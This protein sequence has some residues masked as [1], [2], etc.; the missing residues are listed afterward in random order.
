MKS[1]K[2]LSIIFTA[3]IMN[4]TVNAMRQFQVVDYGLE[5][6]LPRFVIEN[7][8]RSD[9]YSSS[10]DSD[11]SVLNDNTSQ[12]NEI[13]ENIKSHN[14]NQNIK[15]V[16]VDKPYYMYQLKSGTTGAQLKSGTT[17]AQLK[18]GTTSAQLKSDHKVIQLTSDR[19]VIQTIDKNINKV[20]TRNKTIE[21]TIHKYIGTN[22]KENTNNTITCDTPSSSSNN[23]EKYNSLLNRV[24]D[25]LFEFNTILEQELIPINKRKIKSLNYRN[26]L[27]NIKNRRNKDN[28]GKKEIDELYDFV[29][30]LNSEI[31]KAL[32]KQNNMYKKFVKNKYMLQKKRNN[33]HKICIENN[34]NC[35]KIPK[36]D[37]NINVI[38]N[39]TAKDNLIENSKQ[40]NNNQ[41]E[42][43]KIESSYEESSG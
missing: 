23:I 20:D 1:T 36:I 43:Y 17:D 30:F 13:L 39:N 29:R 41:I 11:S 9:N 25:V 22:L 37:N 10:S 14:I 40:N 27:L 32:R 34:N 33:S 3:I 31:N 24:N 35:N 7:G 21:K 4:G 12:K 38:E 2:V 16:Q 28:I 19:V 5:N 15:I 8:F 42:T 18:S 26:K 6:L